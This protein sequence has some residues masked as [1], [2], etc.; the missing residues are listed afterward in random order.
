MLVPEDVDL[1]RGLVRLLPKGRDVLVA[2]FGAGSGT[3]ALAIFAER[4]TRI[5]V[6]SVDINPELLRYSREVVEYIGCTPLHMIF[7]GDASAPDE[8][9]GNWSTL[10]GPI[11]LL[12]IDTSHELQAT[13]RELALWLPKLAASGY[14]WM[15][16]YEKSPYEAE[17]FPGVKKATQEVV[18]KGLIKKYKQAGCGWAG[19]KL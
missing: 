10:S 3:T 15:H 17:T 8:D 6:V 16:D 13:R 14:L 9:D 5:R 7:E 12:L 2:N 19:V 1:I 4:K 18:K 11:D